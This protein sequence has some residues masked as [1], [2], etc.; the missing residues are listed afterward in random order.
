MPDLTRTRHGEWME[1]PWDIIKELH[2]R[3]KELHDTAVV[4]VVRTWTRV[5]RAGRPVE[6]EPGAIRARWAAPEVD[7][8]SGKRSSWASLPPAVPVQTSGRSALQL[9]V[10]RP[11]NF[12]C[13]RTAHT[14]L[15]PRGV[16]FR[17]YSSAS[18]VTATNC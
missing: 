4:I 15:G 8:V 7:E 3:V 16:A 5:P 6:S 1:Q 13:A 2:D 11:L 18:C 12:L 17:S 9:P 14:A 10:F